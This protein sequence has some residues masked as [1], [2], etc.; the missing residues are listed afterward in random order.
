MFKITG[1]RRAGNKMRERKS[2][3]GVLGAGYWVGDSAG[4]VCGDG[5]GLKSY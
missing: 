5:A 2:E 3:K 1:R 4:R